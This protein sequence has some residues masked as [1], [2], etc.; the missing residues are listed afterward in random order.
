MFRHDENVLATRI[1]IVAFVVAQ[2]EGAQAADWSSSDMHFLR[3]YPDGSQVMFEWE[4]GKTEFENYRGRYNAAQRAAFIQQAG[5]M[6]NET[7]NTL[8]KLESLPAGV[9]AMGFVPSFNP[10]LRNP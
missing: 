5:T 4:F 3:K 2:I 1:E 7:T 9:K 8:E 6:L 10:E